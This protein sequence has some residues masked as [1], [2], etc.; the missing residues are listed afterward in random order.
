MLF[1]TCS[2]ALLGGHEQGR[3]SGGRHHLVFGPPE[4]A[5]RLA[6]GVCGGCAGRR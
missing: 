1:G 2:R 4:P 5:L 6:A 3:T